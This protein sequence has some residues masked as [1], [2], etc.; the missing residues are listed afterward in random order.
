LFRIESGF[1]IWLIVFYLFTL[2]LEMYLLLQD[3][4]RI[5]NPA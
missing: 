3:R 2:A 4:P 1:L 5:D